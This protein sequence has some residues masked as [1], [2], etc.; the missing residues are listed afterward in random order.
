MSDTS[1]ED[2]FTKT[3]EANV[4]ERRALVYKRCRITITAGPDSGRTIETEKDTIRIGSVDDNDLCIRDPAVS[5][6][7]LE[8]QRKAGEYVIV[9][10]NSTN[11]TYVGS[12]RVKEAT[13]RHRGEISIGDSSLLFEPIDTEVPVS[14][15]TRMV[16]SVGATRSITV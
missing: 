16:S 6:Y 12:L 10:C 3:R 2:Q 9:D 7:H 13:I 14:P 8:V 1:R 5:R 11:G 4:G 15:V